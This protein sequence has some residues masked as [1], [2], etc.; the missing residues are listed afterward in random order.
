MKIRLAVVP[1]DDLADV[2][3]LTD[4]LR[5]AVNAGDMDGVDTATQKLMASTTK[6]RSADIG[7]DEWRRFLADIRAHNPAFQSDYLI[8]GDLCSR[9]LPDATTDTMV[10]HIPFTE[11]E[12]NDV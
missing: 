12:S 2:M 7:E 3:R 8:P 10:L 9:Y 4:D 1:P 11:R 5:I 6:M